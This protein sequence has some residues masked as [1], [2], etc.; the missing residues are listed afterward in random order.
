LPE[1]WKM[2]QKFCGYT[3]IQGLVFIF[4]QNLSP[5]G[6]VFWISA[7]FMLMSLGS[8]WAAKMYYDWQN[9]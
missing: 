1:A 7:F 9:I 3:A 4:V 6:K 2:F 5:I 8:F